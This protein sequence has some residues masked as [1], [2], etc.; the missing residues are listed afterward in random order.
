MKPSKILGSLVLLLIAGCASAPVEKADSHLFLDNLFTAPSERISA[1]DVLAVSEEMRHYVRVEIANQLGTKGRQKGLFDA[2]YD[3]NQLRLEYDAAIT[4]NAAQAFAARSGNCL[5]L[6]IMTAA[7]AKEIGLAVSYRRV[8]TEDSW[9][10][11]G[12]IYF[13]SGHINITLG[14]K[15]SD[16]R[17]L[18][19]ERN[20]LTI[21]FFPLRPG[22]TQHSWTVKEEA[23]IA[24]YMNNR[25]AE[26]LARGQVNDAYWWAR[27]S[28][29]QD[30]KF[31]SAYNTLGVVY[32]RHGNVKDAER[33]LQYVLDREPANADVI[34]NMILVYDDQG[35]AAESGALARKL[36]ELQ[37]YPPFH[38]FELGQA[39]MREGK[40]AAARD[41][42]AR[43]VER[44][45]YYHEFHFWLAAAYLGLGDVKKAQ[46]HLAIATENSTTR[47]THD[48]YAAKLDRINSELSR[49]R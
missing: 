10:R 14:R 8:F 37:P 9:S 30:P 18:F 41:Y 49:S 25:A 4:R 22:V 48:L 24:M 15:V 13:S 40:F 43:E 11:S 32:R 45:A 26:A 1:D 42:F 47:T 36:K 20:V 16:P 5:S 31:L 34:S 46:S 44:D 12:D 28:I 7:L 35:R 2:L 21:D 38:F 17:V 19:A 3:K 23:V 33:V 39:A 6:V 27:A 29:E